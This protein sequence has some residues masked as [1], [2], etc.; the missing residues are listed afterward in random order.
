MSLLIHKYQPKISDDNEIHCHKE[1]IET[2]M[3]LKH[4]NS[5]P[6]IIFYGPEGSGKKTIL[7]LFLE[8]IYGEDIYKLNNESYDIIGGTNKPKTFTVLE[9]NYHLIFEPTGMASDKY[10]IQN[11][12]QEY[13]SRGS[14]QLENGQFKT[15]V[16][17]NLEKLSNNAL[18]SLRRTMEICGN[19]C[20]FIMHTNSLSKIANPI[21][22]RCMLIHVNY[23]KP[24]ELVSYISH[25]NYK[26]KL[27][28]T[29]EDYHD[30]INGDLNLKKIL[31]K[32]EFKK[33][34]LEYKTT[35][36]EIINTL[37]ET[38]IEMINNKNKI[39]NDAFNVIRKNIYSSLISSYDGTKI[40]TDILNCIIKNPKIP[41]NKLGKIIEI[42]AKYQ[43]LL[44]KARRISFHIEAFIINA[45]NILNNE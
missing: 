44:I 24:E 41:D 9:S 4:D 18:A 30:I 19:T 14:F 10:I 36:E 25:I 3:K 35:Y 7:N 16:I 32:L 28:L 34:N 38:L 40:I 22:S 39:T 11:L 27:N 2:L 8:L 5:L 17:N 37:V 6:H 26:E 43:Y 45:I 1:L 23:P 12:V 42:A 13:S 31:W 33:Y 20:K 21:K 29:Y 15:I